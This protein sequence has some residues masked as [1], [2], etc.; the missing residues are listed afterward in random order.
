[1]PNMDAA[2]NGIALLLPRPAYQCAM[3]ASACMIVCAAWPASAVLSAIIA[4]VAFCAVLFIYKLS[5]FTNL[6]FLFLSVTV[7]IV[8]STSIL[9]SALRSIANLSPGENSDTRDWAIQFVALAIDAMVIGACLVTQGHSVT[10]KPERAWSSQVRCPWIYLTAAFVPLLLNLI[11]Y[12]SSLRGLEYVAIYISSLGPQKY[13]LFLV[14]VTHG[15]FIR[16]FGGW[17]YLGRKSRLKLFAAVCLFLYVYIFLMPMRANLFMFGMYSLYFLGWRVRWRI[18]V[19]LLAGCLILFSWMAIHRGTDDD[20]LREMGFVQAG[21]SAMSFGAPMVEMVP[22]AYSEE[23][24]Q[25]I[26]YGATSLLELVTPTEGPAYRYVKD[27]DPALFENGGGLGFFYIAEFVLDFGYWGGLL[28]VCILGMVLQ[29]IS[30]TRS[31]LVRST[32]LPV[33]LGNSFLLMRNDFVTTLK[34]S[35]YI[36]VSCVILDRMTH[37]ALGMRRLIILEKLSASTKQP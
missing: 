20:P 27:T 21:V 2:K 10:C 31:I 3:V 25:G 18:K 35:L 34:A 11:L 29:Q 37:F 30:I 1:M 32:V 28:A 36:I 12:Y 26:S 33:L 14:A 24:H 23:R 22:W 9:W 16:L 4:F 7:I 6:T 17:T 13:I 19:T 5:S 15:A 8:L